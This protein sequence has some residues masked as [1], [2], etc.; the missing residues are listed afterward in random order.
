MISLCNDLPFKMAT[1]SKS[2]TPV[3]DVLMYP[4]KFDFDPAH[5]ILADAFYSSVLFKVELFIYGLRS[6]Y[7]FC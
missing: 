2:S 7:I 4:L 5:I 6:M 3:F 1:Y